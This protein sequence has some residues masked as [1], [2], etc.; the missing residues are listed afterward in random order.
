MARVLVVDDDQD[1]RD[2]VRFILED[3][4]YE[5]L[6]TGDGARALQ[7]L[8][9]SPTPLVVLLDLLMPRPN[10][11]DVLTEIIAD[12][13]LKQRHAY[14]LL[15]ADNNVLRDTAEPLLSQLSAPTISKPFDVD[16]L[17]ETVASVSQ[18]APS[19]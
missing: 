18:I 7:M 1:I 16:K 8:R 3:A 10:G 15:T 17:L 14:I 6:D 12:P 2:V 9:D 11:I 19:G 5:V 4:G 13:A